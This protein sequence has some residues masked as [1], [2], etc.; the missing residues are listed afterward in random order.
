[1]KLTIYEEAKQNP[2]R[3]VNAF[4]GLSAIGFGL[5]LALS[6]MFAITLSKSW[7]PAWFQPLTSALF[8]T[9][10]VVLVLHSLKKIHRL[11]PIVG[12]AIIAISILILWAWGFVTQIFEGLFNL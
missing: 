9:S 6:S 1:M 11:L 4:F 2:R 12:Y 10:G 3:L 8:L 5:Y 7:L